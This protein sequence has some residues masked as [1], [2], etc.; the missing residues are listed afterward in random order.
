MV[1]VGQNKTKLKVVGFSVFKA[2]DKS[3]SGV[4]RLTLTFVHSC[5]ALKYTLDAVTQKPYLTWATE[6]I[7]KSRS[8]PSSQKKEGTT[9]V[10]P[11]EP[12]AQPNIPPPY[13]HF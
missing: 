1:V 11:K 9:N 7:V 10:T 4:K 5:S 2:Q 3:C 12:T 6:L 13:F 8:L